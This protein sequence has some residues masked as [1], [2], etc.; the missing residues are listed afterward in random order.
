MI[1][2]FGA[3]NKKKPLPIFAVSWKNLLWYRSKVP[4]KQFPPV[5]LLTKN[6]QKYLLH[7][8]T[9]ENKIKSNILSDVTSVTGP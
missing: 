8:P 5:F 1:S 7:L 3:S 4:L 9:S 2:L 6:I